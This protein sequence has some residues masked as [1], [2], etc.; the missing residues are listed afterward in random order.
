MQYIHFVY[1]DK[2]VDT[3]QLIVYWYMCLSV[4]SDA[5]KHIHHLL[6]FKSVIIL[7]IK[8]TD[9]CTMAECPTP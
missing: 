6:S 4:H 7:T 9:C 2:L 1:H 3:I 5:A 8:H